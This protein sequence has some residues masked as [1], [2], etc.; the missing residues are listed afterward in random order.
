MQTRRSL[1]ITVHFEEQHGNYNRPLSAGIP[2]LTNTSRS[3]ASDNS[4]RFDGIS[5]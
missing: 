2:K 3:S 4:P 5:G 1:P